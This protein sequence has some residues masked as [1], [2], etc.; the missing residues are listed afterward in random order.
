MN[1]CVKI[2]YIKNI[3]L[4]GEIVRKKGK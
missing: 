2:L 1:I 4:D 3:I